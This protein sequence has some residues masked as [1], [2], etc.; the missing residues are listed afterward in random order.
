MGNFITI[1]GAREHNLKNISLK[2]PRNKFI[3]FTGLS[4]SGKSTLAFNTI[5]AEGKRRYMESLSVYA[6]QFLGKLEKPE[7]DNIEGLSPSIAIDQKSINNNPRSTV[8]TVTEIYDYLRILFSRLGSP[9][10]PISGKKLESQSLDTAV[11]NIYGLLNKEACSE[12]KIQILAPII[13]N[14]KGECKSLFQKFLEEGFSR[15][16]VDGKLYNLQDE[17]SINK[18]NRHN[19]EIVIDRIKLKRFATKQQNSQEYRDL[20]SRLSQS[21]ELGLHYGDNLL[22]IL[23]ES[24]GERKKYSFLQTIILQS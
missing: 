21:V 19:V 9:H 4:G 16:W 10:C 2:I 15:V 11:E 20:I 1:T 13:R 8:G 22:V 17:I 14:K 7:V 12:L 5:Y 18:N 3:V 6:R 23:Y 24:N